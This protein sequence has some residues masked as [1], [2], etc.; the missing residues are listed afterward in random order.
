MF[1]C[2]APAVARNSPKLDRL[3][4]SFAHV[5]PTST[6]NAPK[7]ERNR[8]HLARVLPSSVKFGQQSRKLGPESAGFGPDFDHIY[9]EIGQFRLALARNRPT[10]AGHRPKLGQN[11]PKSVR[12][13]PQLGH[14]GGGMRVTR[15]QTEQRRAHRSTEA[16]R[17]HAPAPPTARQ[18]RVTHTSLISC[19]EDARQRQT[20]SR[21][22]CFLCVCGLSPLSPS[23]LISLSL[24][25]AR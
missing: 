21:V 1:D 6:R 17:A 20:R 24:S 7:W 19:S 14:P 13:W 18:M 8:P 9:P 11:R 4:P 5:Q 2:F 10:L 15:A 23:L 22:N 25:R 12:C 3:R 16:G